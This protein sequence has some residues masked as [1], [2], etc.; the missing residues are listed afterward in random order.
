MGY[1]YLNELFESYVISIKELYHIVE[2]GKMIPRLEFE[3]ILKETLILSHSETECLECHCPTSL[4]SAI[5]RPWKL[6]PRMVGRL[7]PT[8]LLPASH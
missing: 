5:L 7:S 2:D 4:P 6:D 1:L 8:F 3:D